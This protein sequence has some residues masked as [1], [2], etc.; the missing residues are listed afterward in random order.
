MLLTSRRSHDEDRFRREEKKIRPKPSP[1]GLKSRPEV[2]VPRSSAPRQPPGGS[3][4]AV[5]KEGGE[6]VTEGEDYSKR[7]GSKEGGVVVTVDIYFTKVTE[8]GVVIASNV[9]VSHPVN[10]I[11]T[12]PINNPKSSV[13]I[14][15]VVLTVKPLSL[16][17]SNH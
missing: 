16:T 13:Y 1:F 5:S 11:Y 14:T 4:Q 7:H 3:G 9:K 12:G 17:E 2:L 6:N 10:V 15:T 8:G